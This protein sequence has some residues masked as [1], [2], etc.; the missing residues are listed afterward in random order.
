MN[1][2]LIFVVTRSDTVGGVQI[3]ILDLCKK[4][5]EDGFSV[6]VIVGGYSKENKFIKAM[7]KKNIP[8]SMIRELVKEINLISD[9]R[10][11]FKLLLFFYKNKPKLVS[12]HSSK[13]GIL[14]RIACFFSLT[15][16]IFTAHGW[17]F[18]SKSNKFNSTIYRILE[19]ITQFIPIKMINVS[20]YDRLTAIKNKI[21]KSKL[22]TIHNSVPSIEL[23]ENIKINNYS[24]QDN[25]IIRLINVSR[26]DYQ[27]DQLSI[28]KALSKIKTKNEWCMDFIGDGPLIIESQK[29]AQ[30]LKIDKFINFH[31]HIS[32]TL[33]FYNRADIFVLMSH[34]EGFPRSTIE[35]L[36]SG[37]PIIISNVGG[38]SEAIINNLNGYLIPESDDIYLSNRLE[39]LIDNNYLRHSM[40]RISKDVF[41]KNFSYEN[42]YSKMMDI[43]NINKL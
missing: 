1:N 42:F 9:L 29:L 40:S 17:S 8:F 5:I 3:H 18:N 26:F 2:D 4:L 33:D 6:K 25:K 20:N 35:A 19:F 41:I 10:A 11:F 12:I 38:S 15:P 28:I 16:C 7:I 21:K 22:I 14:C 27:K 36:R 37:L 43:Y 24:N 23:K 39:I 30:N 32:N 31:G 34:W 13:A